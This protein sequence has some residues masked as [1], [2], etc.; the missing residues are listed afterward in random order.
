MTGQTLTAHVVETCR[1]KRSKSREPHRDA[2]ERRDHDVYLLTSS[3]SV[4]QSFAVCRI[5]VCAP[6][7]F[8]D[9]LLQ[10]TGEVLAHNAIERPSHLVVTFGTIFDHRNW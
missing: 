9:E 10:L 4:K 7:S 3:E 2:V 8:G 5:L 6:G 1:P